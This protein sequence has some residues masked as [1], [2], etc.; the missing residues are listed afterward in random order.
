M[1][2]AATAKVTAVMSRM[3]TTAVYV[4]TAAAVVPLLLAGV[5]RRYAAVIGLAVGS[6]AG[7]V[8]RP[9]VVL[10]GITAVVAII[11]IPIARRYWAGVV[12]PGR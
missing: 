8:A 9:D 2:Q 4:R 5:P 12:R 3:A 11:A 7:L 6:A 1:V 10:A